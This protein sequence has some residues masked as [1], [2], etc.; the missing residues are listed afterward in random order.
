MDHLV[1][2]PLD[3]M[4]TL[5]GSW[6]AA[7][8]PSVSQWQGVSSGVG[9]G[10]TKLFNTLIKHRQW[11]L[12]HPQQVCQ[13]MA[14]NCIVW[15]VC[16]RAGMPS[17]ETLTGSRGG[18]VQ[19]YWCS[20]RPLGQSSTDT[21]QA[22][23]QAG[24]KMDWKLPWGEGLEGVVCWEAQHELLLC[25]FS[26][27]SQLSWAV[28][29]KSVTSRSEKVFLSLYFY[30]LKEKTH[31]FDSILIWSGSYYYKISLGHVYWK[32]FSFI[33]LQDENTVD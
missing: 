19:T 32:I 18:S 20:T 23:I 24:Q 16:W 33:Y 22:E 11:D 29:R 15:S 26:P 14:P 17:R 1:N 10:L 31:E 30:F 12:G 6:L 5:K 2:G 9:L 21:S 25:V 28:S 13:P 27:G 8:C 7:W 3:W 4:A